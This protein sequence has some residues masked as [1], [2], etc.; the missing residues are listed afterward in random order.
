[1]TSDEPSF[2]TPL[3]DLEHLDHWQVKKLM[4][5]QKIMEILAGRGTVDKKRFI[6]EICVRCGIRRET[7]EE[8]IRDLEDFGVIRVTQTQIIWIGSE[9]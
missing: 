7:A 9:R 1:M 4:R 3:I 6:A 5:M 2:R 8:Y